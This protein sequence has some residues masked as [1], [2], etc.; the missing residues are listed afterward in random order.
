MGRK[1]WNA[2]RRL[3]LLELAEELGNVAEACRRTGCSRDSFYRYRR[4]RTVGGNEALLDKNRR[5]PNLK[6]RVSKTVEEAVVAYALENPA[7]G[8]ARASRILRERGVAV[9]PSGVRSIWL[10]HGLEYSGKRLKA[11]TALADGMTGRDSV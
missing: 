9:S 3:M 11:A 5:K 1:V 8:Q 7:H 6:N 2:E 4:A 10:R